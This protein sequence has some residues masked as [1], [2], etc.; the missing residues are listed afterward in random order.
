MDLQ[1][2][3]MHEIYSQATETKVWLGLMYHSIDDDEGDE[4]GRVDSRIRCAGYRD[5][6][7]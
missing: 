7:L 6:K 3:Q 1:I 2:K 4:G 5:G